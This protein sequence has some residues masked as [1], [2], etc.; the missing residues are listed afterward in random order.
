VI[1]IDLSPLVLDPR[2]GV[3]RALQYLLRGLATAPRGSPI[4]LGLLPVAS[5]D[6]ATQVW[7]WGR[8]DSVRILGIPPRPRARRHR[9]LTEA[10]EQSGAKVMLSPW[11]A[12]PRTRV[13]VVAWIHE[14][15]FARKGALEGG[16]RTL[17]HRRAL[18]R[19]VDRAAALVTPSEAV[20]SD[21]LHLH[22][23]ADRRTFVVPHGY[24]LA[25][26][27]VET[28]TIELFG[29]TQ[30]V[31]LEYGPG[32]G[33][34]G[35]LAGDRPSVASEPPYALMVGTGHLAG[36]HRKKG[37]DVF[38]EA[39]AAGTVGG[40]APVVVGTTPALP[41]HVRVVREPGDD[42]LSTLVAQARVVVVPSRSEGF[43]YPM[44]EG[45]AAGVPVVASAA[46]ALPEVSGGA[47]RLVP[48]GDADAL[49]EAIERV[50]TDEDLRARMIKDGKKR[51]Q[52]FPVAAMAR[53]WLRVLTK[54]G[55]IPWHG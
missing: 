18:A 10:L 24:E 33:S 44:L 6:D 32:P 36:G 25:P 23:D 39:F 5:L 15:P 2:R 42:A 13:P 48:P 22:P 8:F 51:A 54:V 27:R 7:T 26:T 35:A 17:R 20:R 16:L 40:L 4:V 52:E 21:L 3:S 46:G 49:R 30:T 43:G 41:L 1:A 29:R 31:E 9:A 47:A 45:F 55:G 14:V 50:A 38:L 37:L 19:A 12:F 28:T 34:L 53:G 11:A